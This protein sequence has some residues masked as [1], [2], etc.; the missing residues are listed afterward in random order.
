MLLLD[1]DMMAIKHQHSPIKHGWQWKFPA[2]HV[3]RWGKTIEL[4]MVDVPASH[5]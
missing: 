1:G 5:F 4:N 2:L 3:V